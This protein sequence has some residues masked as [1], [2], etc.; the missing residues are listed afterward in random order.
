MKTKFYLFNN[1]KMLT[2]VVLLCIALCCSGIIRAQQFAITLI[3]GQQ[4]T[5]NTGATI[6]NSDGSS[7]YNWVPGSQN[8]SLTDVSASELNSDPGSYHMAQAGVPDTLIFDIPDI[9]EFTG[10]T[11][12]FTGWGIVGDN[13]FANALFIPL[14]VGAPAGYKRAKIPYLF[15]HAAE[16]AFVRILFHSNYGGDPGTNYLITVPITVLGRIDVGNPI[17]I[18]DTIQEPQLPYLVLHAPPGDESSSEFQSNKTTCRN[19]ETTVE[20][21][22]SSS[23]NLAVKLGVAGSAGIFITTEFEFSVTM[24]AGLTAGNMNVVTTD[25]QT[26]VTVGEGFATDAL[27]GPDGD[28]DVFIGY[29][30]DYVVGLYDVRVV[31]PGACESTLDKALV[32][33]PIGLPRKFI[34]TKAAIEADIENL[35]AIVANSAANGPRISNNA[36]NQIDVWNQV[37]AMNVENINNPDNV[38]LDP[39]SFSG[40]TTSYNETSITVVE[41]NTINYQNYIDVTAG[42]EAVIEVGGSGVTGGYEFNGSKRYG[43]TQGQS[44]EASK[45][46]KYTLNDDDSGDI[47]NLQVV[48]DPMFG[49][50]IFKIDGGTKSSC[51]YQGGYQRD[52]PKLTFLDDSDNLTLEDIPDGTTA[53]FQI[54]ICNASSEERD[55]FLKGNAGSNLNGAIVEGFGNNLFSTN[56]NGVEFQNVPAGGCLTDATVS[57]H[58]PN[59]SSIQDFE[60]IELKLYP[61]CEGANGPISSSIFLT[62]HF[63]SPDGLSEI[64]KNSRMMTVSPNPSNGQFTIRFENGVEA[65]QLRITDLT[66]KVIFQR[67]LKIGETSLEV[68]EAIFASGLYIITAQ[69]GEKIMT[70]KL[71]IN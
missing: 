14:T 28:G 42:L 47:F 66:G 39:T 46:V 62:A 22:N 35:Q 37:L 20:Q 49:T 41:T 11:G 15:A 36:Q 3:S 33:A 7:L 9:T 1:A 67:D 17:G 19:F 69:S 70:K 29:G 34:Y 58:Q 64:E 27:T 30:T 16:K 44:D 40:S 8:Y 13:N 38:V 43:Q 25:N 59:M 65:G 24:S 32:Y 2:S 63:V 48:R 60:N 26:C 21:G 57:I 55:Y 51:P 52:Q 10:T 61:L 18:L 56:D 12:I 50:P 31:Q 4:V 45:L 54:K 5:F 68:N 53:D 71:V 6:C 23:A